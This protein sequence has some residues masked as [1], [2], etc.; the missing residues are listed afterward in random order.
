VDAEN[1]KIVLVINFSPENITLPKIRTE[2]VKVDA[3]YFRPTEVDLLIGDPIK[4]K[5]KLGWQ[6]KYDLA[7]MVEEM[8]AA[9]AKLFQ[10]HIYLV[11]GGHIILKQSE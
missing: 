2:I 9:D 10:R 11:K 1:Y 7:M 5:T 4:S 3:Q 8:V 6:P